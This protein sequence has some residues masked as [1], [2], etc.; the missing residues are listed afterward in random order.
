MGR[1]LKTFLYFI[2]HKYYVFIYC[3]QLG[4]PIRGIFHDLSKLLPDEWTVF[5][6]RYTK[7]YLTKDELARSFFNHYRRNGHHWQHWVITTRYGETFPLDMPL[8]YRKEML[9]DWMGYAA[10]R[11]SG[12]PKIS[13]RSYYREHKY[14]MHLHPNTEKW[15]ETNL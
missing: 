6:K 10:C 1:N 12:E 4:I 9:A 3:C 5:S 15:I 11:G 2:K 13:A 14:E 7:Q 8:K